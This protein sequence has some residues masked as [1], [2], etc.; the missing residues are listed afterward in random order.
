LPT[1]GHDYVDR[2]H[3]DGMSM[4]FSVSRSGRTLS[5]IF[6]DF[7]LR[8]SN[9]RT[10]FSEFEDLDAESPWRLHVA[11][12]GSFSG[13]A[14]T[15]QEDLDEFT[16]SEEFWLSGTFTPRRAR[17]L[18]SSSEPARSVRAALSAIRAIVISP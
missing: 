10:G 7:D 14:A 9:G 16:A 3:G 15:P 18:A 4:F 1:K 11:R 12:E 17:R 5:G 13:M 8:C 2:A 6:M